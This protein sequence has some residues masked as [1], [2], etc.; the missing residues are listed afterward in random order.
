MQEVFGEKNGYFNM[1]RNGVKKGKMPV[2]KHRCPICNNHN[3]C[4]VDEDVKT[5]WCMSLKMDP[6]VLQQVPKEFIGVQC[7]CEKCFKTREFPPS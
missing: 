2:D 6:K 1:R 5:C 7:I 3:Q 4:K